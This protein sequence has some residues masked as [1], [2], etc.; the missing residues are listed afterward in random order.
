[1]KP[2]AM[3]NMRR[4]DYERGRAWR[5]DPYLEE[6]AKRDPSTLRYFEADRLSRYQLEKGLARD[7]GFSTDTLESVIAPEIGG[8]EAK[9]REKNARFLAASW[10]RDEGMERAIELRAKDPAE[11]RRVYG[12]GSPAWDLAAYEDGKK[13]VADGFGPKE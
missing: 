5:S 8:S 1:M 3:F 6:L 13:A 12:S 7:A 10:Q 9:I 11:F 2:E 4:E